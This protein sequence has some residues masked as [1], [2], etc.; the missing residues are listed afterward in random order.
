MTKKQMNEQFST[1]RAHRPSP[2]GLM[3]MLDAQAKR[4]KTHPEEARKLMVRAGVLT[5]SGRLTKPYRTMIE[6]DEARLNAQG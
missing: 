4:F 2:E 1:A 6:E 5:R 3:K